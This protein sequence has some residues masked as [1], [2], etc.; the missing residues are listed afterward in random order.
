MG[1]VANN[2]DRHQGAVR[3]LLPHPVAVAGLPGGEASLGGAGQQRLQVQPL[4]VGQLEVELRSGQRQRQNL[5]G[6]EKLHLGA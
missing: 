6:E 3:A 1:L 2:A 4:R 5:P